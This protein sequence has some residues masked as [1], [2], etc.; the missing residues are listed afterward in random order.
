M[1]QKRDVVYC[2]TMGVCVVEEVTKLNSNNELYPYYG[3][4]SVFTKKM[5]YIPVNNSNIGLREL[6]GV[7]EAKAVIERKEEDLKLLGEA[8]YVLKKNG[9]ELPVTEEPEEPV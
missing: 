9:Q 7:E 1:F 6:I 3:L 2:E 5:A 4:R 8:K